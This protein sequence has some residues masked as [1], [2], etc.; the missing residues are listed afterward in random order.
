[1]LFWL[2]LPLKLCEICKDYKKLDFLTAGNSSQSEARFTD[3][4]AQNF[5]LQAFCVSQE[6]N[7]N[8]WKFHSGS[9]ICRKMTKLCILKPDYV[10]EIIQVLVGKSWEVLVG[11]CITILLTSEC[12][13]DELKLSYPSQEDLQ[14]LNCDHCKQFLVLV[15]AD[16]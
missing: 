8:S 5:C 11:L 4:R 9:Q 14:M 10:F 1:M 3:L 2:K 12:S 6:P 16:D 15:C 13:C 7:N